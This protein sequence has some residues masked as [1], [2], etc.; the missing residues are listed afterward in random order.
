MLLFK[1]LS[2]VFLLLS[3][4]EVSAQYQKSR[5]ELQTDS[6]VAM[7]HSLRIDTICITTSYC[8]GCVGSRI[9][10]DS[11]CA[12]KGILKPTYVFWR[13]GNATHAAYLDNCSSKKII[14]ISENKFWRYVLSNRRK[15]STGEIK[16]FTINDHGKLEEISQNHGMHYNYTLF[17]KQDTISQYVDGFSLVKKTRFT[18]KQVKN[19]HYKENEANPI[20]KMI[21]LLRQAITEADKKWGV[22][23]N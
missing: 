23:Q 10:D 1:K 2:L 18:R 12:T 4:F 11:P 3:N 5:L 15:I 6:L 14:E 9:N 16:S 21:L 8:V 20:W 7:L 19:I 13:K 17:V 22:S